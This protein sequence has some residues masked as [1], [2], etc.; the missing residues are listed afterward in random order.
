L[1]HSDLRKLASPFPVD[2]MHDGWS[3]I[4]DGWLA[5]L[6]AAVSRIVPVAQP[7]IKYRQHS[8][9]Q[10]GVRSA[11]EPANQVTDG[12]R[13]AMQRRNSFEGEIYYLNTIAARLR[14]HEAEFSV[15]NSLSELESKLG[16]L[17]TRSGMAADVSRRLP[18]VLRELVSTRY[19]RY[20]NGFSSAAKDL[21]L[22]NRAA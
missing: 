4:H 14:A 17:Q 18:V 2:V 13:S 19:H 12:F 8:G 22:G 6:A 5:L 10:L 7:L 11:F 16:H 21:W 9:Q 15:G 1:F 3:V 20:S